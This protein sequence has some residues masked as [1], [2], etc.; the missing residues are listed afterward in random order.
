M[1]DTTKWTCGVDPTSKTAKL[2]VSRSDLQGGKPYPIKLKGL[3][4]SPSPL[5]G[6]NKFAPAIGDWFWDNFPPISGWDALWQRDLSAIRFPAAP[7]TPLGVNAIRIYCMLSR[8][9][10][11]DG[12]IP[13]PWNQGHLFTHRK[14]LDLCWNVDAPPLDRNP[15]FV[16]VGV[17]L[18]DKMF[19][20]DKYDQTPPAEITYW[21]QVL[22][23]TAETVGQ[24]PAVMGFTI[25]NEQ[26]GADVC[27]NNPE[28]ATFWWGQVEKFAAVV[29]VVA[30]DKLVG[31]AT[32]DDPNIPGK[33]ASYMAKCPHIDFW[34]V[35]T[36]QTM[37]FD[38]V[39]NSIPDV[40]PGYSGLSG[41]ALKPVILT[42]YGLPAT[43]HRNP[44]DPSTIYEDAATRNTTADVIG[45]MLPQAYQHPLG[46]GLYY[47]EFCDE[48]WNQPEAPNI[49]TWWG[50]TRADGFPDGW[51]DQE[52]FGLY[53][54]RRGNDLPNNA[55]IWVGNGPNTPIDFHTERTELTAKVRQAFAN[56]KV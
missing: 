51:W 42:E 46:L 40:G 13:N 12:S 25:Q 34:G 41:A 11:T 21:T 54:I 7:V 30:P 52:G 19:W 6:S 39:F 14:F 27:Y 3:C 49:Y 31:M 36:Y 33:A 10:G 29:K 48:W 28:W 43:S 53:S 32:H 37:T 50:G 26:D 16:L 35:N 17:P 24:H 38:P 44:G 8:Q 47:F 5:N 2:T 1:A 22:E 23:E 4:Y 20:K 15:I 45:K 9:L 56:V 55:P 18:P